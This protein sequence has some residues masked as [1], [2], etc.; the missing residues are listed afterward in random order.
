MKNH[1]VNMLFALIAGLLLMAI[2]NKT[3]DFYDWQVYLLS[4]VFCVIGGP[5]V[6]YFV[7]RVQKKFGL[8]HED[9]L[10]YGYA[11][12]AGFIFFPAPALLHN[13]KVG[14]WWLFSAA[15]ALFVLNLVIWK[16]PEIV[17]RL[18]NLF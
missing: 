7:N 3:I 9:W 4:F 13:F 5:G 17:Q 1:I 10:E 6:Q 15:I 14:G 12:A 18:K 11:F 16:W 8:G 2:F